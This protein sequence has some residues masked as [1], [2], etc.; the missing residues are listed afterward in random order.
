M[1]GLMESFVRIDPQIEIEQIKREINIA[2]IDFNI[3]HTYQASKVFLPQVK[4][5]VVL[6]SAGYAKIFECFDYKRV[7]DVNGNIVIEPHPLETIKEIIVI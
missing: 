5:D 4:Y 7:T 3:R 6:L 1:I 2:V